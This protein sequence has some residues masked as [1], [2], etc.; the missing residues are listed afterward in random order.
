MST[1]P[2]KPHVLIVGAGIGGLLL[3]NLLEKSNV[4]YTIFERAAA[5]KPLGSCISVGPNLLAVFEQLGIYEHFLAISIPMNEISYFKPNM[6]AYKAA[7]YRPVEGIAGYA[8]RVVARPIYYDL[9]LKQIPPHKIHFGKRVLG[10]SEKHEKVTVETSDNATWEGDIL[11]G[12]DGAYS[13]VRQRLYERLVAEGK[14]PKSDQEELPFSAICLVGQTTVLDPNEY[15]CLT[16][17][18]CHFNVVLGYEGPYTA[19]TMTTSEQTICWMTLRHLP[20]TTKS[21][22]DK[23]AEEN[24]EWGPQGAQAMYDETR[25]LPVQLNDGK[26]RLIGELYDR[27]PKELISKIALDEKVF[28]TWYSGRTVLIGDACHKVHPS[29]GQGGVNAMHDAIVLANLLYA[30]PSSTSADIVK[31]FEEYKKERHPIAMES[32]NDAHLASKMDGRGFFGAL[33]VSIATSVPKW[34]WIRVLTSALKARPQVG[35]LPEIK[36]KGT[37][38]P[39]D[40]PSFLKAKAL[41]EKTQQ[42]AFVS[43]KS[44]HAVS[45]PADLM[46]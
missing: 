42:A 44:A 13:T 12:A 20:K 5:V 35:F 8:Y 33:V 18:S 24:L 45:T 34:L 29:R 7:D 19:A 32:Y 27:T 3:G 10:I 2:E 38:A 15:P 43:D 22:M 21:A 36:D 1:P 6:T 40:S 39:T 30:L 46:K 31:I 4:P 23:R 41:F 14:L 16:L 17:P 26:K 37:V 9:L 11:V 28:D 25:D